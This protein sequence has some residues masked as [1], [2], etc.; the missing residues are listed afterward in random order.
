MVIFKNIKLFI[1]FKKVGNNVNF[2]LLFLNKCLLKTK[3][4]IKLKYKEYKSFFI[5]ANDRMLIKRNKN[6]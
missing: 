5:K 6:Q 4:V 3:N 2:P 1:T